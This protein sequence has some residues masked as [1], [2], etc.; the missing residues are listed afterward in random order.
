MIKL[1]SHIFLYIITV[2]IIIY[3]FITAFIRIKLK[4][5]TTQPVFHIYN[6]K[7][8]VNPPGIINKEMP[9]VNKYLN[10]TNIKL[11]HV[12]DDI[13]N[14]NKDKGK[15]KCKDKCKDKGKDK[16]KFTEIDKICNFLKNN[17]L[18][19][20]KVDY[21]PTVSDITS[22]LHQSNHPSFFNVYY[23]TKLVFENGLPMENPDKEIIG[24]ISAR[25]LNCCL[26]K[27]KKKYIF[28]LYYVDNLCVHPAYRKKGIAPELIQ[29]HYY[30]IVHENP[31]ISVCLFK[32][33][34]KLNPIVPLVYFDTYCFD[35]TDLFPDYSIHSSISIIEIGQQ[36]LN[37]VI[38]FIKEQ[39]PR[40]K[41]YIIPDISNL[42]YL[43]NNGKLKLY[44]LLFNNSFISIYVFR[45]LELYYNNKR[46]TECI[47]II[48]NKNVC[49][50]DTLIIGFTTSLSKINSDILLLENTADCNSIIS[51]LKNRKDIYT[52][53]INPTAFFL[54]NYAAHSFKNTDVLLLY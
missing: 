10:L 53:F 17:Y 45:P 54:Y 30:N 34:G 8:W 5:W 15:D 38:N 41:C 36:H 3:L 31:K 6:L 24:V 27:N 13:D 48:T 25:Q 18:V 9:K 28:P 16:D 43:I 21:K 7:Y 23:E 39:L 22:Y 42:I 35:I 20:S 11:I 14:K 2:I 26:I 49:N 33:E 37:M 44:G 32:R 50:L 46:A 4:F 29:T 47:S 12:D 51:Y 1:T 40:F 19:H 52:K